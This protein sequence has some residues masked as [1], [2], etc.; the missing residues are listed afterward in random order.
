[1]AD[2]TAAYSDEL[3]KWASIARYCQYEVESMSE[4]LSDMNMHLSELRWGTETALSRGAETAHWN[5]LPNNVISCSACGKLLSIAS[6]QGE[7]TVKEWMSQ[8]NYCPNCGHKM[9]RSENNA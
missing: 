4:R 5:E 9:E 6:P 2:E 3:E 8:Y 1:M 7:G